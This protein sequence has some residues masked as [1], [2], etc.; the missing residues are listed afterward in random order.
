MNTKSLQ[1][2]KLGNEIALNVGPGGCG[3]GRTIYKTGPQEQH[4][5]VAGT[6]PG[7]TRDILSEFGPE[8][9]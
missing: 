4:G 3:T 8:I 7:P 1:T 6:R 2:P 9:P 5:P